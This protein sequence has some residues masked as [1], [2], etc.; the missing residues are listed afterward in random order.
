MSPVQS[1]CSKAGL[2]ELFMN[3]S[4]VHL[5]DRRHTSLLKLSVFFFF[6]VLSAQVLSKKETHVSF[7]NS[8]N[9]HLFLSNLV[10]TT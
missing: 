8:S 1:Q 9:L 4:V 3:G 2:H 6:L 7:Y 5:I 10:S